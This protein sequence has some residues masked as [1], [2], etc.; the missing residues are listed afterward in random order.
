MPRNKLYFD[1]YEKAAYSRYGTPYDV[2]SGTH[3][4]TKNFAKKGKRSIKGKGKTKV[5]NTV[6]GFKGPSSG[7]LKRIKK[8]YEC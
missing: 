8:F 5:P 3:F 1:K 7:D 4:T 6:K 2:K